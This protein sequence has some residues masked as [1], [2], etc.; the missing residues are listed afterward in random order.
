MM[1][2]MPMDFLYE[3]QANLR[4]H[5]KSISQAEREA[6]LRR[7]RAELDGSKQSDTIKA[8]SAAVSKHLRKLSR[9]LATEEAAAE[10]AAA[11]KT[12]AEKVA[13]EEAAERKA[14]AEKVAA[15]KA[16]A[17]FLRFPKSGKAETTSLKETTSMERLLEIQAEM[18]ADDIEVPVEATGWTEAQVWQYFESGGRFT[19]LVES[20]A[21]SPSVIECA[22]MVETT[23]AAAS[24]SAERFTTEGSDL[25]ASHD[26]HHHHQ[27]QPNERKAA[28]AARDAAFQRRS[29]EAVSR[30][31]TAA[32]SRDWR[33]VLGLPPGAVLT[34]DA[35]VTRAFRQQS[36]LVH[37]DKSSEPSATE[38]FKRLQAACDALRAGGGAKARAGWPV[39]QSV[40]SDET[41]S[42]EDPGGFPFFDY[43]EGV[44]LG[45]IAKFR[46]RKERFE[47]KMRRRGVAHEGSNA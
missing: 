34:D 7:M 10:K 44:D 17:L 32:D 3:N 6:I 2:A 9:Y 42:D 27:Q 15:E 29:R 31:L 35:V 30:I 18:Y 40:P 25:D 4:K 13:A 23:A 47:E 33:N 12:A 20:R 46:R 28:A 39:P 43:G 19:P 38:A 8:D 14:A 5:E 36:R 11:E 24:T 37:P 26:T 45:E 16:A 21:P 22:N 41:D 1:G